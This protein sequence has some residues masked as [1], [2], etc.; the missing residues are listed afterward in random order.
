MRFPWFIFIILLSPVLAF[1]QNGTIS[2]VVTSA[3]SKKPLARV[4]VFL[5]NSA[6]GSASQENG[7]YFL[8]NVRPGSYT[9]IAKSLGYETFQKKILVGNEAVKLDIELVVKPLQ[10]REVVISSAADWKKN[11]EWFRRD[12]I[13]VDDNARFCD[14]IN[15]H[16]LNIEY[17]QTKQTLTAKGDEFL[18]VENKALGYRI[19]FLVDSFSS[20]KIN[21]IISYGGQRVFEDMPGSEAQKAKWHQKREEVYYGSP[22]HFYRSL[23]QDKLTNEGFVVYN[24]ARYINSERPKEE[25]LQQKLKQFQIQGRRDSFLYYRNLEMMSKY[26]NEHLM[27][28]PLKEFEILSNYNQPGL[29]VMHFTRFLYL[30][31]TKKHE[32]VPDTRDFYRPI[33]MSDYEASILTLQDDFPIFDKNGT[34]VANSALYEGSWANHRLSDMLPVDYVP[35]IQ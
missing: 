5:D 33:D 16:I 18:V 32:P 11:Y 31:Y 28:P 1:A 21:G 35:D 20:D 25:I 14:V 10:L 6:V 13:G 15:P 26:S 17:N 7:T 12:F 2:G 19:K 34:V 8:N 4:S 29:Y 30:V 22:M 24:F 9:V 23:Y 3:D 27:Q